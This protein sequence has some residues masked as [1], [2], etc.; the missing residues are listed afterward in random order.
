MFPLKCENNLFYLQVDCLHEQSN[1]ATAS[2]Q[3]WHER[4]A[5]KTKIDVRNLAKAVVDMNIVDERNEPCDVCNTEKAER[6]SISRQV[7]TRAKKPLDIVHV[8]MSPVNTASIDEFKYALGFIDSFSRLGAVYLLRTRTEV[9]TKLLKFIAE[10]GK[11][12]EIVTDNAKEFKFGKFAAICLQRGIHQEFTC[13]YTPEQNGKI[14]RVWGTVGSMARCLLKLSGLPET[15]WSFAYRAAFHIKSRCLHSAH[16]TTPFENLFDK[17]P[18]L[19]YFRVFGCQA[20]MYSEKPKRK[21]IESRALE[22]FLLGYSNNSK[23]YLIGFFDGAELITK[24]SL[25][26]KFIET[27][28]PGKTHFANIESDSYFFFELN[29]RVS[30]IELQNTESV[31]ETQ[32]LIKHVGELPNCDLGGRP[33]TLINEISGESI[34]QNQR[35]SSTVHTTTRY[36]QKVK[37]QNR[38]APGTSSNFSYKLGS[39]EFD[40]IETLAYHSDYVDQELPKS[41]EEALSSPE[42][43]RAMKAEYDSLQINEVWDIV[44]MP[45]G[46]NLS[47]GKWHFALKR[48]SKGEIIRHKTKYVARGFKQKRG[49]DY[50][51][52]YSP[53]VKMVKL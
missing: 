21:K 32:N 5:H 22:G 31:A 46:K 9:G 47:T 6:L 51:Q 37:P 41:I 10:L 13:K 40:D 1:A 11:P 15:F 25:N 3:L 20:F 30:E 42:W 2:L 24:S 34:A 45:E 44:E 19:S 18:C 29:E 36:G 4:L 48:N 27:S 26:V 35:H 14:E 53:T 50:D 7:A 39:S 33:E 16:G 17:T 12:R 38:Y 52:K 43:Y 49:V 8:D 28:F 23:S